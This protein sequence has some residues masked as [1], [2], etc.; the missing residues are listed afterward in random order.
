MKYPGISAVTNAAF[1][2]RLAA[3]TRKKPFAFVVVIFEPARIVAP[4]TRSPFS[5][6]IFPYTVAVK[7]SGLLLPVFTKL[8]SFW[9][10]KVIMDTKKR[11]RIKYSLFIT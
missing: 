1:L 8:I 2:S 4:D 9:Q 10:L 3:V 5:S 6:T 11:K 7:G